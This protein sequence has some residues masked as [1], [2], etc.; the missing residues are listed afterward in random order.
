MKGV[1]RSPIPVLHALGMLAWV[2]VGC[3]S[4][5]E[6]FHWRG[7][8][9]KQ[10]TDEQLCQF[11]IGQTR[12]SDV[13]RALGP[14]AID[15]GGCDDGRYLHHYMYLYERYREAGH[16]EETTSFYFDPYGV[17]GGIEKSRWSSSNITPLPSCLRTDADRGPPDWFYPCADDSGATDTNP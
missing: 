16:V 14:P 4:G 3:G 8:I 15:S 1:A 2:T 17:L 5:A 11:V 9:G 12:T 6:D 13:E 10:V 7:D